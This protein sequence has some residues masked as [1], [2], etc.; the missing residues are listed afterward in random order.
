M[1]KACIVLLLLSA[2]CDREIPPTP[3]DSVAVAEDTV[4]APAPPRASSGWDERAGPVLLVAGER[5]G[6]V[7]VVYPQVPGNDGPDTLDV[8]DYAE[9]SA[10][11]IARRGAVTHV[12]LGAAPE[13]E[14]GACIPWPRVSTPAGTPSWTVGFVL[15][16]IDVVPLDSVAGMTPR[17]SARFVADIARLAST[18]P[19]IRTGER[20]ESFHG[21]PFVVQSAARFTHAATE[22]VVA[23]V[24]RR[25]NAE[26]NPLE[27]HTLLILERK[28]PAPWTVAHASHAVGPE[29]TVT[30]TEL[31]G[32]VRLGGRLT[33]LL[34]LDGGEGVSYAMLQ[35]TSAGTWRQS[36]RSA[37]PGC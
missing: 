35:R 20:A 21:L 18:L 9:S 24:M 33:L 32:V 23:Q 16:S 4:A 31:L 15:D 30:R 37:Q 11:L 14:E 12:T 17:D 10:V 28:A 25:V 27:E 5:P 8:A 6:D 36:W 2:A 26:A 7:L 29:E 1:R 3:V 34:A 19:G 13:V 22:T